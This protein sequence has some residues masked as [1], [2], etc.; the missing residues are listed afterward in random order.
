M[1]SVRAALKELY[2]LKY[3]IAS[4]DFIIVDSVKYIILNFCIF[5][6]LTIEENFTSNISPHCEAD[7]FQINSSTPNPTH[8]TEAFRESSLYISKTAP[9]YRDLNLS[10]HQW[11]DPTLSP[12]QWSN[13]TL[14][15]HQ[16]SDICQSGPEGAL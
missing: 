4:C 10:P 11:S 16:W 13:P 8:P 7:Q 1:I 15:P 5:N 3:I 12:H 6:F 9:L 14:S 2:E